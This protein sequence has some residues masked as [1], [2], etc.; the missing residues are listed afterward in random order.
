MY[1]PYSE[2]DF[3]LRKPSTKY[4]SFKSLE[5]L[6]LS[7]GNSKKNLKTYVLCS[8]VL[9]GNGEDVFFKHFKVAKPLRRYSNSII[10]SMATRS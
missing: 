8:G 3:T 5:T 10:A 6:C 2:K 4:E 1:I 7:A 9:Y